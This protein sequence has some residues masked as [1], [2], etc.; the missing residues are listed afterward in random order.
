MAKSKAS[1]ADHKIK[2]LKAELAEKE[3][4]LG[5]YRNE[6]AQINLQL[7]TFIDQMA[8]ELKL[9]ALLQR[10]LVPSEIPT[11][12]GFTFSN[13]FVASAITGGDYFDIFELE[14]KMRFGVI[15][16]SSSGHG[17]AALVLSVLL[18]MTAKLE[19][20]KGMEPQDVLKT[21]NREIRSSLK[22]NDFAN[23]FYCTIDRRRYTLSFARAGVVH[24][25]L[26]KSL[27]DKLVRLDMK[28]PPI[29]KKTNSQYSAE[30]L[31][32]DPRDKFILV[33]DGAVRAQNKDGEIFGEDRLHESILKDQKA[34]AHEIRN[35]IL[36]QVSKH[37][38]GKEYPNDI[39]V[40][41]MSVKDKVIKL[42][43][44]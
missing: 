15:M 22:T 32:L 11:I 38:Q 44:G 28:Q 42:R 23:V 13:K 25:F 3:R 10:T 18:K 39:S 16:A 4:E 5:E 35:E 33:S 8:G 6:L 2:L 36:Y 34:T 9:A 12:P 14:D 21:M 20:K 19:A 43:K 17:M 31:T 37:A 29:G 40:L 27:D 30:I 26:Y 24:G 7:E 1:A 41:V